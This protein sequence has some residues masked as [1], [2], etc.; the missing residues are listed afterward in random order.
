MFLLEKWCYRNLNVSHI[1]LLLLDF[2]CRITCSFCSPKHWLFK[3]RLLSLLAIISLDDAKS[4]GPFLTQN[5]V[6]PE[7]SRQSYPS[8][9][10]LSAEGLTSRHLRVLQGF[11][12]IMRLKALF[13]CIWWKSLWPILHSWD[14]ALPELS[15]FTWW[16]C[17][18]KPLFLYDSNLEIL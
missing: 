10:F 5:E 1:M 6:T 12:W 18:T 9:D 3:S 7:L 8:I 17:R 11:I 4:S 16:S 2:I 14:R 15:E 13:P